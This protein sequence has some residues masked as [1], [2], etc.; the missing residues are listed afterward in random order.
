MYCE[1]TI[2]PTTGVLALHGELGIYT[3]PTLRHQLLERLAAADSLEV[4]LTGVSDIDTAGLQ[5]ML[6]A[7]RLP[8]KTVRF[9]HHSPPVLRL[10]A[11]ANVAQVLGDPLPDMAGLEEE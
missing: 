3:V 5:L 11:L 9:S 4:D 6:L 2:D 7:K 10:I 8:G 1:T